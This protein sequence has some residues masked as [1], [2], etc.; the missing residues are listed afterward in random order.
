MTHSLDLKLSPYNSDGDIIGLP[1]YMRDITISSFKCS[2]NN[3]PKSWMGDISDNI[4]D[5]AHKAELYRPASKWY[6][7]K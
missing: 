4:F 6:R 1:D 7:C 3:S 2:A 5:I